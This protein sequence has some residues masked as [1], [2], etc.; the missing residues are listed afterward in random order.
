MKAFIFIL[1]FLIFSCTSANEIK[2]YN[3]EE[4]LKKAKQENKLILLDISAKWCHYCNLMETTTYSN[5]EIVSIVNQYYIPVK[6]D[7]DLRKD[8]NKKYNQGGLPTTA[9]LT[10]DGEILYGNLYLPPDDMKKVLMY[11]AK[12]SKEELERLKQQKNLASKPNLKLQENQIDEDTY[13]LIK[14]RTL[15]LI[16]KEYGGYYDEVKFPIDN[17]VYFLIL[18]YIENE[19]KENK[20]ILTKTLEGYEKLIDTEEGG[21]FR[22]ATKRDWTSPHYEKLLRDQALISVAFFNAYSVLN[23]KKLLE[24]A[25]K[26]LNFAKN[27]LYDSKNG[28]FYGSQGADIVDDEG[29]I[30]VSGEIY[31]SK[32]KQ[33]REFLESVYRRKLPIDK[34]FY[35]AENSLMVKALVYSYIFN[36]NSQDL[37]TAENLMKKIIKEGLKDKGIIHTYSVKKYFLDTQVNTLESLF[38]LYQ[39][40]GD[41]FYLKTFKDLLYKVLKNY[42]SR[43]IGLYTDYEDTGLNL[44]RISYIDSLVS[45]NFKLAKVIYSYQLL[46]NNDLLEKTKNSILKRLINFNSVEAGLSAYLYLKPPLFLVYVSERKDFDKN[47]LSF[48]PYWNVALSFSSKDTLLSKIGYSYEGYPVVY[49]CSLKLCFNKFE[50]SKITKDSIKNVF[51]KYLKSN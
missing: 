24:D 44:N 19:N 38:L 32:N 27:V 46:D 49:V 37:A 35:F 2:W 25:N 4:G 48:F 34:T 13:K 10:P 29:K 7:A 31:F 20:Q 8:I 42:Y 40:T 23:D 15:S 30:L 6:V 39:V 22:Y 12:L 47:L 41:N 28:Y 14:T 33:D 43:E 21:I 1:A 5:P 16:D 51:K 36:N 18:N 50:K 9:I 3:F 11:F 17:I 26:I 45:I